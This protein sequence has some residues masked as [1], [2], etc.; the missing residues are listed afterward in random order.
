ML[1]LKSLAEITPKSEF[2]TKEDNIE[3]NIKNLREKI[4][5]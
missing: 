3:S 5:P 4:I 2:L 1:Y